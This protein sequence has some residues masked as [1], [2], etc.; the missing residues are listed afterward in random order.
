[1]IYF[2]IFKC[3]ICN[4]SSQGDFSVL[5]GSSHINWFKI[6]LGK[7]VIYF[8]GEWRDVIKGFA[9]TLSSFRSRLSIQVH[10]QINNLSW[11]NRWAKRIEEN[12]T[13][14]QI[15]GTGN[16]DRFFSRNHKKSLFAKLTTTVPQT[17]HPDRGRINWVWLLLLENVSINRLCIDSRWLKSVKTRCKHV[18]IREYTGIVKKF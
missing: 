6:L 17:K 3:R 12:T 9:F 16:Y 2:I 11:S 15:P 8:K 7:N 4:F 13:W 18:G 10:H 14:D 1:M 5:K